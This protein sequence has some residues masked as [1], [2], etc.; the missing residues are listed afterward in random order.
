M[1][2]SS[3]DAQ[4]DRVLAG[5]RALRATDG[6][7]GVCVFV[8]V[9]VYVCMRACRCVCVQPTELT[10]GLVVERGRWQAA[11]VLC[12]VPFRQSRW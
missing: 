2:A 4:R 7:G 9:C 10:E 12:Q 11:V 6:W 3:H 1:A 8:Y 5:G